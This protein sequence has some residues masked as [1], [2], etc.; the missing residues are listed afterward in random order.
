MAPQGEEL[1]CLESVDEAQSGG[2]IDLRWSKQT[3]ELLSILLDYISRGVRSM[4]AAVQLLIDAVLHVVLLQK[5]SSMNVLAISYGRADPFK[6]PATLE[7]ECA[8]CR[9]D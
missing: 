1:D 5:Y 9:C 4:N 6:V 2:K 8:R 7:S 3:T